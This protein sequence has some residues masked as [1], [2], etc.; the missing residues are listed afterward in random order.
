[1]AN[2]RDVLAYICTNYPNKSQLSKARVNKIVYL[3]DWFSAKRYGQQITD[4]SWHFNHYG[5]Y[6]DD[7]EELATEDPNFSIRRTTNPYGLPKDVIELGNEPIRVKLS[8]EEKRILD[9]VMDKTCRLYWDD[10]ISFVYQTYPVESQSRYTELD[11]ESLAEKEKME[12]R[13]GN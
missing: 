11:L 6:V 10:F 8:N 2:L 12:K 9:A 13:K 7:I 1:M 4:I 3:A 5:P